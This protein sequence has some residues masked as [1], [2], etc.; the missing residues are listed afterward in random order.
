MT[1]LIDD[2]DQPIELPVA[3]ADLRACEKHRRVER[4]VGRGTPV[5]RSDHG[6]GAGIVEHLLVLV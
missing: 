1:D 2:G 3:R 5:L 4:R 6:L